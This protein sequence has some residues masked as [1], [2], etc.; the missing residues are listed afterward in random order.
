MSNLSYGQMHSEKIFLDQYLFSTDSINAHYYKI[1]SPVEAD[2]SMKLASTFNMA[3]VIVYIEQYSDYEKKIKSGKSFAY[4]TNLKLKS[5][6]NFKEGKFHDTLQTFYSDGKLK[7]EEIYKEGRMITGKCFGTNGLDTLYF[8]YET[9]ARYPGGE[10][11][12]VK[13]L[14]N[15]TIYPKKARKN[16]IEG[17]VYVRFVVNKNGEIVKLKIAKSVHPLLDDEAIKVVSNMGKWI[18]GELDGEKISM[19]FTLPIKFK[20]E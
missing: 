20:L 17:A 3:G 5:I 19:Y 18:P 9:M 8:P 10:E 1:I 12:M 15:N 2:S 13:Y 6:I 11:A 7:R 4:H 16:G 14:K